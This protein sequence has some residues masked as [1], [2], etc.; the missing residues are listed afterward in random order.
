[1]EATHRPYTRPHKPASSHTSPRPQVNFTA[2]AI[3]AHEKGLSLDDLVIRHPAATFFFRAQGDAMKPA[4]IHSGDVLTVD[5][6]LT[7]RVGDVV[8]ASIEGELVVRYFTRV[9]GTYYLV[10]ED[11]AYPPFALTP[12][13]DHTIWGVVTWSHHSYRFTEPLSIR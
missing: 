2:S 1:M 5:R 8:V 12:D 4:G 3:D 13:T 11:P 10:S 9:R 6:S 7:P